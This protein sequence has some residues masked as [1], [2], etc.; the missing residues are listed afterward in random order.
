MKGLIVYQHQLMEQRVNKECIDLVG[1]FFTHGKN[2]TDNTIKVYK[3]IRKK[4]LKLEC[5]FDLLKKEYHNFYADEVE[6]IKKKYGKLFLFHL[7][8]V[9]CI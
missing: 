8:L 3:N 7:H 9:D 4:Y 2:Q 1:K 6:E 5:T